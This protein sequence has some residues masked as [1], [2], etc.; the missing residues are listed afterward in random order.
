MMKAQREVEEN[1]AAD[2]DVS[3]HPTANML[4]TVL[5]LEAKDD[6][7][8]RI[9]YEFGYHI[10]RW[11]YLID[12]ADDLEKD[13]RKNNFNPF[14]NAASDDI[15]EFQTAVLNQSLARAY[16]AYNLITL[17]DFKGIL[18]NMMLYGFPAKQNTVVYRLEEEK[19]EQSI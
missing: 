3:A 1:A 12:A 19:N 11:I 8:R 16:D 2:V 6:G 10:G 13:I 9:L 15:K 17:V 4:G 14:K 18:D 7:Q 5:S